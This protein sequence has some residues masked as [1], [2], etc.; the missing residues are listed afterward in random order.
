MLV[1]V[2]Q[3]TPV[4]ERRGRTASRFSAHPGIARRP[5][6]RADGWCSRAQISTHHSPRSVPVSDP[7]SPRCAVHSTRHSNRCQ[8]QFRLDPRGPD[9]IR[10]KHAHR[11]QG[12]HGCVRRACAGPW[13]AAGAGTQRCPWW[14]RGRGF[15][16]RCPDMAGAAAASA[17]DS[18]DLQTR[19]DGGEHSARF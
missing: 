1:N 13:G 5:P 8:P 15:R 9:G 3:G 19:R 12:A 11:V 2:Q 17:S 14:R 10:Q 18:S 4:P 16:A 6:A 7:A